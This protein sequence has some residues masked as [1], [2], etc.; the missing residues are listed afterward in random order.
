MKLQVLLQSII[1]YIKTKHKQQDDNRKSLLWKQIQILAY[2]KY[3][4]AQTCSIQ[5]CWFKTWRNAHIVRRHNPFN[6]D[7]K[8]PRITQIIFIK[9]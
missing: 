3:I 5:S 9:N 8:Q 2:N 6:K 7:A 1:K 4:S